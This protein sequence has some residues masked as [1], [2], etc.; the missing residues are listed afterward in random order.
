MK[1][2]LLVIE[3]EKSVA[4]QL[5]W[6][7][8]E[9]YDI[10]IASDAEQA[11]PL[12][13]SGLFPVATLDL[14]LPPY[15]DTPQ[16]G[17]ALL[18][19]IA[20]L[21]PHTRVIVITGNAEDNNAIKAI[22]LGAAD[23]YAKPIDLKILKIILSRTFRIQELEDA[24]RRLQLQSSKSGSLCGMIGISSAMHKVFER[25][26]NAGK[27]DYPVLITGNTGTGKE[28]AAHAVHSLSKRA[29]KPLII[30]NCGAIPE[31]L[32]ESELFGHEKGAFTGATGRQIGKFEL[33]D[34]GTIFLDEIGELPLLLQV[35]ILRFLQESTIERLGGAKTL[36]LD[37]RIIAATNINLQEAVQQKT[38]R[39][40]LFY[41]LNVVPLRIP[42]LQERPE[43]ILLLAHNFLQEEARAMR[44]G[45]LSFTPSAMSALTLHSWPGNVRELQNRIRRA[46]GTTT[47]SSITSTDLGLDQQA[48]KE[49]E[50]KLTT[51]KEARDTSE[52]NA[53]QQALALSGNNISQ[54]AKLLEVSRPTLHDL[55][56]KHD[57][58][59][60]S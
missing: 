1:K 9:E 6:G 29:E 46:L 39:E 5:R 44:R 48:G 31:N 50:Q 2:K 16:Q 49:Q 10:T 53:V 26:R 17:F 59:T 28:M 54:A 15:P 12:L 13:T 4:K 30:I 58:N 60:S 56:K 8:D 11:K 14:G 42:D 41:R 47:D 7:L 57:I 20:S 21:A 37:V 18:E 52:K 43:D 55:L 22:A 23:F 35:K 33:A 38:F 32:L 36:Q 27:T 25:L 45:Q 24:N 40:D 34:G 19:E 3:D 51:L